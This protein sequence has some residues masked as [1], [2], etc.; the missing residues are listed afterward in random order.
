MYQQRTFT[1]LL[2]ERL[3]GAKRANVAAPYGGLNTRDAESNMEITDAVKMDNF[4]PNQGSVTTRKGYNEFASGLDG[5][6]ETLMEYNANTVRK[7][8]CANNDEINDVTDPLSIIN[9]GSGFTNARWQWANFNAFMLLFNGNDTPQKFDGATLSASTINGSGLA[10]ADLDGVNVF[11]NRIFAWNSNSQDVWYGATNAIEGTFTKFQ[12]SRVATFGGNLISMQTWNLDGGDGVDDYALFLMSSGDVLMYSGSDPASW[13][14]VGTYKIGRPLSI[15]GAIKLAGDVVII[16]DQDFVFFSQVFKND[17]AVTARS[18]LSGAALEV[19]N[20]YGSNYGWQVLLYPKGAWLIFNV[21]LAT[22][23]TYHQYIVNTIT[24]AGCRFTN[25]NACCWGMFGNNLYFGGNGKIFIADNGFSDNGDFIAGDVQAAYSNLNSPAEKVLN[26][27][28]NIIKTDGTVE[29]NSLVN[30][31]YG[32]AS[33]SQTISS[34]SAGAEWDETPWD[35]EYWSPEGLSRNELV[36]SSGS[37]VDLGMRIKT[38][39][40]G[41][42]FSWFRTDYSVNVTNIL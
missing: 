19:S 3:G 31:D 22:N 39:L 23:V 21:P 25:M 13:E 36:L 15:R 16:T 2:Q 35:V 24:G 32:R 4:F 9:K 29:I 30:F 40:N 8:L 37:G 11:K 7:F 42:Q 5:Y 10:P 26:S 14:L 41:Q 6:V 28:R 17:G 18:K 34:S 1:G 27:F 20:N 33:T 38:N 12:L